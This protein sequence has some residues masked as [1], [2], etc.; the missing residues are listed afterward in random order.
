MVF[1]A[2][3]AEGAKGSQSCPEL[4]PDA[5]SALDKYLGR[6]HFSD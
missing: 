3:A 6:F 5:R 4:T 2:R 1:A